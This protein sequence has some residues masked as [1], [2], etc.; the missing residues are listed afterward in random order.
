MIDDQRPTTESD[1]PSPIINVHH[2]KI[3]S[4]ATAQLNRTREWTQRRL[5]RRWESRIGHRREMAGYIKKT[6][7]VY[8]SQTWVSRLWRENGLKP[9]RQGR[10]RFPGIRTLRT[11]SAMLLVCTWGS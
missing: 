3:D 10:S 7:G 5:R 11:R 6:E 8:V 9:W 1:T 4:W 2:T